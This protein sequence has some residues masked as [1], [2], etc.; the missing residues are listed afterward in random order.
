M[1]EILFI[2]ND[3]NAQALIDELQ[4]LVEPGIHLEPDFASGIKRIFAVLPSVVF[5]QHKIGNVTCDKL[6]K[7]VRLL[8]GGEVV[9][10]VLLSDAGTL[11]YSEACSYEA[12]F[13][14]SQPVQDLCGQVRQWLQSS[15][16]CCRKPIGGTPPPWDGES[17]EDHEVAPPAHQT[18]LGDSV[19]CRF[20][21]VPL[22]LDDP[23]R[24]MQLIKPVMAKA[25]GERTRADT[26]LR[27]IEKSDPGQLFGSIFESQNVP[28]RAT[29]PKRAYRK[30]PRA[31]TGSAVSKRSKIGH[32]AAGSLRR[33]ITSPTETAKEA[34]PAPSHR[35]AAVLGGIKSGTTWRRRLV[36]CSLPVLGIMICIAMLSLYFPLVPLADT[37]RTS[38]EVSNRRVTQGA[39][40]HPSQS[41]PIRQLPLF[42]PQVP[43]DPVYRANHPGW[44]RYQ[45]DGLEYKVFS[46]AGSIR[47]IQVM[48]QVGAVITPAFLKTCLRIGTGRER[49]DS[50]KI[51]LRNGIEVSSGTLDNGVEVAVYRAMPDREIR[52]F[53]LSFPDGKPSPAEATPV[54][55]K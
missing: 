45:S 18:D 21:R 2:A 20:C 30:I 9:P 49:F 25:A 50:G 13:D 54:A 35:T 41:P 4:P 23:S 12:H 46:E 22:P 51:E 1:S 44:E 31:V 42:I 55:P 52:G 3:R 40:S 33:R 28:L 26:D 37:S 16:A 32:G 29:E 27:H 48:N 14:L 24:P 19:S 5:L 8:L 11:P 34:S 7:Q 15:A 10:M 36:F 43:A 6:V 39:L 38:P 47:A 53:V 17:C